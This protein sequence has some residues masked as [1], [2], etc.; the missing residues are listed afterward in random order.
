MTPQEAIDLI[1]I[2]IAEV[3][4]SYTIDYAIAFQ[5]AIEAL[6]KQIANLRAI[7]SNFEASE[8]KLLNAD[9]VAGDRL[10]VKHLTYG[11]PSVKKKIE[12]SKNTEF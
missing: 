3:E 6:E 8:Q 9:H 1:N 11:A 10:T 12:D 5:V 7:K 4:W 2:A